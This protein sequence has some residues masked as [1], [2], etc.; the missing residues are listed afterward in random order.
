MLETER[1]RVLITDAWT[2]Y[3]DAIE[4]LEQ[5]HIRNAAEKA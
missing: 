2:L 4:M 5:G 3:A 1:G